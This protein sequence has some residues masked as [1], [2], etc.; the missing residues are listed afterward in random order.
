M[1]KPPDKPRNIGLLFESYA[2]NARPAFHLDRPFD[3]APSGGT[4]YRIADL[5][6]LVE[7]ASAALS[8]A[9]LRSGDRLAIVK[10]NHFDVVLL[11]A[12]AA[13]IGA[14]PAMI[15][16]TNDAVALEAMISRLEPT[17]IFTSPTVLSKSARAGLLLTSKARVVA[18]GSG[19]ELP[20]GVLSLADVQG[21]SVPPAAPRPD[22]EPMIC[23]H[24]SGTTGLPKLAVHSANTLLGELS[25]LETRR[26]PFLSTRPTDVT[27]TCISFVHGR[28]ITWANAQLA[29]SPAKVVILADQTPATAAAILQTHQP[30]ILEACPNIYQLWEEMLP[31]KASAFERVRAYL[32]TF[33]AIH[34]RTVAN[35]LGA[36]RR[37]LP[38][39]GQ[40]WGQSEVG[41]VCVGLYTRGRI[42]RKQGGTTPLTSNVGRQFPFLVKVA[43]LDPQTR[44]PVRQGEPG[45]V[46][47]K[48]AGR[49]LTYLGEGDRYRDKEWGGGW[50]NT[51]DMGARSRFGVLRL[52]DREVDI[53][54]GTSGIAL[55]SVLLERLPETSEVIVLGVPGRKPAP[56]LS[57]AGGE[58]KPERWRTAAAGL[59]EMEE[60]VVIPWEDFPRTG[61]WKVRRFE[62]REQLFGTS[63][64]YG[65]GQWT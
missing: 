11:S 43:V 4:L 2:D 1:S 24:T 39:W 60:P 56:V 52:V 25:K 9:G 42:R 45:I 6:R 65:T 7:Q 3:I 59:P 36:S 31:G 49:C 58:L 35:F 37:R 26:I 17:V 12:A 21:G 61:T 34:P 41:P 48:T 51:G 30:T 27:A 63:Q 44:K 64:T 54:P 10:D 14:L 46:M 55:E 22:D 62:L 38:V 19:G 23:T 20:A 32:N 40:V 50:W 28:S 57:L 18:A 16:P 5:A 8:Q 47:V 33:D 13:R 53:I 29:R 15:S